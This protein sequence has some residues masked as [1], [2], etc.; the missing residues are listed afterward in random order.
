MSKVLKATFGAADKPLKIGNIEIPCYVL[1][2]GKRVIV[3]RGLLSALGIIQGGRTDK[4]KQYGGAA[5]LASFLDQNGLKS[6][7]DNGLGV[8]QEPIIFSINRT[9]HHGYEATVLQDIVKAISK[10]YLKGELPKRYTEIGKNAE[11]LYDAFAKIGIIALVDE[12][13]G[14]QEVRERNALYKILEAYISP[15]LLPWTKKFPDEF[16]KEMFRLN[17]W[18][19]DP[20]SVKRPGVIGTWTNQLIYEQL[21]NGVLEELRNKTPKY[22]HLHRS[23]TTDVGHPHLSNQLAAVTAIMRL[24]PNWRKFMSNFAKAFN[25]G[26]TEIDFPDEE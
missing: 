4:Y 13:T 1:E 26:Q 15:T 10:A 9:I 3:Q 17:N 23:L 7:A 6:F 16:Y 24:S 22:T 20:G 12:V 19:Y 18:P 8:L 5:R 14:Y 2:D 21:P 11:I 25:I